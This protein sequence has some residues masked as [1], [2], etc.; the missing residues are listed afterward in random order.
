MILTKRDIIFVDFET[1]STALS[2]F[3]SDGTRRELLRIAQGN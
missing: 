2:I 3:R 1:K